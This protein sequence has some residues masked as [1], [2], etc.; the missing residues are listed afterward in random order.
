MP[1]LTQPTLTL[2]SPE[3]RGFRLRS[4]PEAR[5]LYSAL[6]ISLPEPATLGQ[7]DLGR[8]GH[9][10]G[11]VAGRLLGIHLDHRLRRDEVVRDLDALDDFDAAV[12]DR[13]ELDAAHRDEAVDAGDAEPV[14]HV[15]HQLLEAHVL[16]AGDAFGALEIGRGAVAAVLALAR[17]VDEE[18][19]DLAERASF[20]AV[21]DD[22]AGAALLRRGDAHLDAMR[23]IGPAGA[24]VRAEDVGAV[25]LVMDAAGE[26]PRGVGDGGEVLEEIDRDAPD[27]PQGGLGGGAP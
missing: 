4:S 12:D 23:E 21:V 7:R 25:A 5:G 13:F 14:Q 10:P 26:L 16:H 20:L 6:G 19:G 27:R 9:L 11:E 22:H 3:G 24:D 18:L 1:E 15:G 2:P 8:V 17:V